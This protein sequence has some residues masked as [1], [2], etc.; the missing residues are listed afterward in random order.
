M[1][2]RKIIKDS[3]TVLVFDKT[4]ILIAVIRSLRSAA[5]FT[6]GNQQSI[7]FCCTGKY[8]RSNGYYFRHKHPDIEVKVNDLNNLK[9]ED[10][11][12]ACGVTRIYRT[13]GI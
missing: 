6:N 7:S 4:Q 11:D 9:L 1:T 10:Y 8:V 5:L 13:K 12:K 2:D 3:K